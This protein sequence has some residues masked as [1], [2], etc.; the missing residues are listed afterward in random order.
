MGSPCV[1]DAF[2]GVVEGGGSGEMRLTAIWWDVVAA[3]R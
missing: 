3:P 2:T 1:R